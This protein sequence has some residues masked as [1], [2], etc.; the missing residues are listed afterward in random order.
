VRNKINI[1][2]KKKKKNKKEEEKKNRRKVKFRKVLAKI[3]KKNTKKKNDDM[4]SVLDGFG[5]DMEFGYLPNVRHQLRMGAG[6]HW[7][8]RIGGDWGRKS[9]E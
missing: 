4:M 5:R 1:I 7:Q 9:G 2:F 3:F 8:L 6:G